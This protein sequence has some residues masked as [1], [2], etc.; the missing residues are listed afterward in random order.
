M[1]NKI[2]MSGIEFTTV[3]IADGSGFIGRNSKFFN[4]TSTGETRSQALHRVKSM[5]KARLLAE[6]Q[7]SLPIPLSKKEQQKAKSN[8]STLVEKLTAPAPVPEKK[9]QINIIVF[10]LDLSGSMASLRSKLTDLI[11]SNIDTLQQEQASS[12]IETQMM[13]LGFNTSYNVLRNW[14]NPAN[15]LKFTNSELFPNGGT[16]LRDAVYQA[17]AQC[18]LHAMTNFPRTNGK[19][20]SFLVVTL[21]DGDDTGSAMGPASFK[22]LI[23]ARQNQG[24]WTFSFLVPPGA[25]NSTVRQ[26]GVPEGNVAEWEQ[27]AKGMEQATAASSNALR[28]YYSNRKSGA[29]A[30]ST[31]FVDSSAIDK[32]KVAQNL[33]D[34][35]NKVKILT[36]LNSAPIA[37]FCENNGCKPYRPGSAFYQLTKREKVQDY[38]LFML[39]YG[40]IDAR[41]LLGLPAQGEIALAPG[42]I[43]NYTVFVQSTSTNRNLFA[44]NKVLYFVG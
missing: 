9:E 19:D 38:K 20:V 11:N 37:P 26:N 17:Q 31:F 41:N 4:I 27:S 24:N 2:N 14:H 21:T 32:N 1:A 13:V 34:I 5:V 44:G 43:T 35:R 22:N 40:G 33:V 6:Q 12:G 18:D 36:V 15:T 23:E 39:I 7:L 8:M 30:S 29:K 25:R 42:N 10:V 3:E 16:N 28:G